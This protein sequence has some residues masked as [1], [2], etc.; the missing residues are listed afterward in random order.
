MSRLSSVSPGKSLGI[1][2]NRP[3]SENVKFRTVKEDKE[4]VGRERELERG[5]RRE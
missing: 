4:A 2:L 5:L 3:L 1:T